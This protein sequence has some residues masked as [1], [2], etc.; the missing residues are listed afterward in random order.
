MRK[1]FSYK[2]IRYSFYTLTLIFAAIGFFL[3]TAYMA[4]HFRWT[5]QKGEVDQ[6]SRYL[7][8]I[9]QQ[10]TRK[11]EKDSIQLENEKFETFERL[12]ILQE[13][14][15]VN[16]KNILQAL[17][18]NNNY[19][20]AMRMIEA[21]NIVADSA[22]S[23][24]EAIELYKKNKKPRSVSSNTLNLYPWMNTPE[25][26][27]FKAAVAK[28]KKMID[29]VSKLTGV[30]SRLIVCCLVGEQIRIF[31]S[32]REGFKRWIGPLKV[33]SVESKFS[34]GVTGIKEHTAI[35]IENN[36]KNSGSEFYPGKEYE[37]LL[38]FKTDDPSAERIS[39]LTSFHNH[40][41]SYL[42]AALFLKQIQVQWEQAGHPIESR[43]EILTTLFNLGFARSKPNPHPNVGGAT[44]TVMDKTYSFGMIGYQFY[45]SGELLDLFPIHTSK[46]TTIATSPI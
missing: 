35:A 13:Y 41:Y 19:S 42:Y 24:F 14:Y 4:I 36:I 46:F 7:A 8:D 26:E 22:S 34:F 40:F 2:W 18:M 30:E 44:I 12:A 32:D 3:C 9:D 45:Y 43:P 20:E 1:A 16:A 10:H 6:N 23:Y 29:S 25:W 21:I 5:D 38:N 11:E 39:R 33:L 17:N 27:I 28:D 37:H 15:P 31:N